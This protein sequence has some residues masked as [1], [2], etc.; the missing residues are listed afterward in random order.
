MKALM[1][2]THQRFFFVFIP[3]EMPKTRILTTTDADG[4]SI[5]NG[6][7]RFKGLGHY[8]FWDLR[9][10]CSES[11]SPKEGTDQVV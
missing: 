4:C 6:G 8:F 1:S 3:L 2:F 11:G 7:L 10:S 5:S 9:A